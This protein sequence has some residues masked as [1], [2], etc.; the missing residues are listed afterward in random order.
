M[1]LIQKLIAQCR[2]EISACEAGISAFNAAEVNG[3]VLTQGDIAQ[4]DSF[5]SRRKMFIEA[6]KCLVDDD[7]ACIDLAALHSLVQDIVA[8]EKFIAD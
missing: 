8:T 1:K 4:R 6:M 7:F 2:I 5:R 3:T